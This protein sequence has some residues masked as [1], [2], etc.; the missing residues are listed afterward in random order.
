VWS[1]AALKF[2]GTELALIPL[3]LGITYFVQSRKRDFI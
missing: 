3:L 1:P 2:L